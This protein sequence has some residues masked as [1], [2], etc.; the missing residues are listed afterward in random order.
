MEAETPALGCEKGRLF[1]EETLF[2]LIRDDFKDCTDVWG[3]RQVRHFKSEV[4][5][6][7]VFVQAK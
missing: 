5:L 4:E 7:V 2:L 1:S 6:F 3:R